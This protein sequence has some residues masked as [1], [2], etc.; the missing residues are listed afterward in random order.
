MRSIYLVAVTFGLFLLSGGG[1]GFGTIYFLS[2][3]PLSCEKE[4]TKYGNCNQETGECECPFGMTG[5]TCKEDKLSACRLTPT[6][7]AYCDTSALQS[8]ECLAQCYKYLCG[9]L[10]KCDTMIDLGPSR[11]CY[12]RNSTQTETE[13]VKEEGLSEEQNN[14][15]KRSKRV[16]V[17][18]EIEPHVTYYRGFLPGAM[19]EMAY[20][21]AV[22]LDVELSLPLD[23]CP[24]RCNERGACMQWTDSSEAVPACQCYHG[25]EGDACEKEY[26][27][28]TN[29]CSGTF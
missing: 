20:N 3:Q 24:E 25:F 11:V 16:G 21:E 27:A 19:T 10:I 18:Y 22:V 7:P 28:C 12:S 4:C 6:S 1:S 23:E 2:A 13:E 5:P 26:N 8:C 15:L 9:P 29:K 14:T 17:P